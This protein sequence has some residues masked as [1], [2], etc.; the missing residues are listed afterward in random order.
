MIGLKEFSV[1]SVVAEQTL[2]WEMRHLANAIN[3]QRNLPKRQDWGL[4]G[5]EHRVNVMDIHSQSGSMILTPIRISGQSLNMY[6]VD[7][8]WEIFQYRVT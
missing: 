4:W 7:H 3:I 8:P 1:S 2:G 6:P 5:A